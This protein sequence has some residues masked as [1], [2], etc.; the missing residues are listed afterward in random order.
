LL[1]KAHLDRGWCDWFSEDKAAAKLDFGEAAAKLA[2]SPVQAVALF[3]LAD[4]Q[5]SLKEYSGAAS[6]YNLVLTRYDKVSEVTNSL[7]DLALYQI[8]E[9]GIRSGSEQGS[10]EASEAVRRILQSYP[11][12]YYGDRGSLLIGE[13]LDR[14]NDYAKARQVFFEVMTNSP[15]SSMRPELEYAIARTYDYEGRWTEAMANYKKWETNHTADPLL[16]EV[17]FHL[18]LASFKAG[19]TNEAL[20][21]FTNFV[22]RFPN[23]PANNPL[24]PWALNCVADFYYNHNDFINAE[25]YYQKLFQNYPNAGEL[26]YQ[27]LFWAGRSALGRQGT[28]D[29]HDYFVKLVNLTN[30]SPA[31]IARG[32]FALSETSFQQYRSNPTNDDYLVQAVAAIS[33]CTNGAPTNTI[34]VEALGRL[35]DYY[36]AWADQNQSVNNYAIVKQIYEAVAGFP[37]G[38]AGVSAA[39]RSQA[40]FGLGLIAQTM[41][42]KQIGSGLVNDKQRLLL[43]EAL[44]HYLKVF[45]FNVDNFDPY[46]MERAGEYAARVCEDEQHWSEAVK[47]YDRVM[48]A[49]P[50]LRP[51]LERKRAADQARWD[52]AE[53]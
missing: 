2:L 37:A 31:L 33:K 47:V 43:R 11:R 3:K 10:K 6:N 39:A 40:E 53:K 25:I 35:G 50:A 36:L 17:E 16:P 23:S 4:A 27:A 15:Q 34:A 29:A 9:A 46:W 51:A 18:A 42:E 8:A 21:G 7:F 38:S 26:A 24:A 22:A 5:Y 44:D 48:A 13:D 49:V 19:L 20:A 14:K 30:A 41:A 12:S 28:A 45:D 52:A 32:Y 1:A